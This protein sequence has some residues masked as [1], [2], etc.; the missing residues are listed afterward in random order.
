LRTIVAPSAKSA[1]TRS[2]SVVAE[3]GFGRQERSVV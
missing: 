1:A 2:V 3:N